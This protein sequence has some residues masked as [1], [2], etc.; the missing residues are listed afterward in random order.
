M[1]SRTSILALF[2]F[3]LLS[4]TSAVAQTDRGSLTGHVTD[5][6]GA[7]VAKAKVTATNINTAETR[8]VT[9]SDDGDYAIPELKADPYRV[10][11][12]ASGFKTA[13]AE[14]IV[15]AVQVNSTL[16]FKLEIGE[17]STHVTITN[18]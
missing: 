18:Y 5:P 6:N 1:P 7:G 17:I 9:T 11:V 12:E 4:F 15:S 3:S 13:A 2:T 8:E 16:D 10:T 14:N